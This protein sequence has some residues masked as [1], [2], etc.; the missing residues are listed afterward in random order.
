M[1]LSHIVDMDGCGDVDRALAHGWSGTFY[2]TS[3][4]FGTG[5][6]WGIQILSGGNVARAFAPLSHPL[7]G[8]HMNSRIQTNAITGHEVWLREGSL[9]CCKLKFPSNG[10]VR[11]Y[12]ANNTLIDAVDP[13]TWP[14]QTWTHIAVNI[15]VGASGAITIYLYG[16]TDEEYPDLELAGI[17]TLPVGGTGV[18]DNI[19]WTGGDGNTHWI[20]DL[21]IADGDLVSVIGAI[22][23]G[24]Y[25]PATELIT[26]WTKTGSAFNV[27]AVNELPFSAAEYVSTAT[28]GDI[29]RYAVAVGLEEDVQAVRVVG[30]M[31][32]TSGD[33]ASA[34]LQ[35]IEVG[36]TVANGETRSLGISSVVY[37]DTFSEKPSGG[38]WTPATINGLRIGPE[39]IA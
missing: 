28:P 21:Y 1:A 2:S 3:T 38:E 33:P 26:D 11:V 10:A 32:R 29:D 25:L 5:G 15:D 37:S 7:I 20:D 8:W 22:V 12:D 19:F 17:D 30:Q 14:F 31:K 23:I 18:I 34:R 4:T 16:N 27:T 9:V 6:G 35:I 36:G 13:Q 39:R 24:A